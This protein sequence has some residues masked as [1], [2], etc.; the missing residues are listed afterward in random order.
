MRA[1]IENSINAYIEA[2][3]SAGSYAQE[4][5]SGELTPSMQAASPVPFIYSHVLFAHC[6]TLSGKS[7][8]RVAECSR[9][10]W[11]AARRPLPCFGTALVVVRNFL[12]ARP[13]PLS[14]GHQLSSVRHRVPWPNA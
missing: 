13:R 6:H 5:R 11:F 8:G 12:F 2:G 14:S 9:A 7:K 10:T 3:T 4:G 1:Q